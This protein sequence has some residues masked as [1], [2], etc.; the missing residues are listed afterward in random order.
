MLLFLICLFCLLYL[1]YLFYLF[2][3]FMMWM[4]WL[5]RE[6]DLSSENSEKFV[7]FL[8]LYLYGY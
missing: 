6:G 8:F 1:L 2:I 5:D 7:K 3:L 4:L